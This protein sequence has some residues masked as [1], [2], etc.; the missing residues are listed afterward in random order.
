MRRRLVIG[1]GLAGVISGSAA[2]GQFASDRQPAATPGGVQLPVSPAS[3]GMPAVQ[4][5]PGGFT[6]P[7]PSGA[8][9]GGLQPTPP[10][11]PPELPRS[12]PPANLEIQTALGPNH[13]WALKP[14]HGPF[15]ISVK[16]YSR[17]SRPDPA[18][19]GPSAR[20]LAEALATEIR[21]TYRVQ[22]FL[23]EHVSEERKAEAA[24]VAAARERGRIFAQQLDKFRQQ[25][26]L[27]GMEFLDDRNVKVHF[28]TVNYRDQIAVLIGPFKS[29][30]DARKA[31]DLVRKWPPPKATVKDPATG[32]DASLMDG[33]AVMRPGPDGKP[34][35]EESRLNP[36]LTATVVP[37]PTIPRANQP[38]GEVG[39]DPF[40]VKLNEGRPYSLLKATKPWTLGVRSFGAP[41]QIVGKD[42]AG[43]MRKVGHGNGGDALAAGAEQ[44][45]ALAKVLRE[46]KGPG[47]QPLNLEAF[48]LH[49]RTASIVTVGQFD[50]PYD[51]A[52]LQTKHLLSTLRLNVTEDQMGSRPVTNTP[53][54][55]GNMMPMPV[56]RP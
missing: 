48:V 19:P 54:L 2:L 23:Y 10:D 16:S 15:F 46:M 30:E 18:D 6:L 27:Q 47:G 52:L 4:P 20:E 29:D 25:S 41:V 40:V 53:S 21:D 39:L 33:A 44:A 31:L 34:V 7:P 1:F 9:F 51:P 3:P 55:F 24:A 13:P 5:S 37:N 43:A 45:E 17:P 35:L 28:K 22:A 14:E 38:A 36:Y 56:P 12:A 50:G 11:S 42:D 8:L 32:K 26:Q 49:T